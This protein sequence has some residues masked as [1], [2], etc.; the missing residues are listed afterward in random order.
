MLT[1]LVLMLDRKTKSKQVLLISTSVQN[2]NNK[3]KLLHN[4]LRA[5]HLTSGFQLLRL[6]SNNPP[7][8]CLISTHL[9]PSQNLNKTKQLLLMTY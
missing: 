7:Q 8:I 4:K 5:L 2:L 3:N 1:S 9:Q 6:N